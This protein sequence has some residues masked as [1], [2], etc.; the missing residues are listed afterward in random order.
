MHILRLPCKADYPPQEILCNDA[1][2]VGSFLAPGLKL[3]LYVDA[4]RHL[5]LAIY[6]KDL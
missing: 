4:C 6:T 5:I 3:A 1:S 2:F